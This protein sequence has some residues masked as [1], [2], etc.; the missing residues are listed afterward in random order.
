MVEYS[1]C[2]RDYVVIYNSTGHAI[3]KLC[4]KMEDLM[5]KSTGSMTIEFKTDNR[6]VSSGFAF[7]IGVEKMPGRTFHNLGP[8]CVSVFK[9]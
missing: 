5:V 1:A 3:E 2:E 9:L 7:K 4:G 8:F 6:D